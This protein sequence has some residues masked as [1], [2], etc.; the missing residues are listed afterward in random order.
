MPEPVTTTEELGYSFRLCEEVAPRYPLEIF[1]SIEEVVGREEWWDNYRLDQPSPVFVYRRR[2]TLDVRYI[3]EVAAWAC[4]VAARK[5]I[6]VAR[7]IS[8]QIGEDTRRAF[9][10]GLRPLVSEMIGGLRLCDWE[11]VERREL[12]PAEAIDLVQKNR[13]DI[14]EYMT[15]N[16]VGPSIESAMDWLRPERASADD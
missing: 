5:E 15:S 14:Y 10:S 16:R 2:A 11:L 6:D 13:P 12:L 4:M 1:A 8:A 9:L 3:T 7:G